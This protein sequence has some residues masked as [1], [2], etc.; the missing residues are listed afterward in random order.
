M[1]DVQRFICYACCST[2]HDA[3]LYFHHHVPQ[4]KQY[5]V[6]PESEVS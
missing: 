4:R 3:L 6:G 1:L 2:L 5:V